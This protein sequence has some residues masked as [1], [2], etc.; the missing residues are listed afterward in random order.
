MGVKSGFLQFFAFFC[1]FAYFFGKTSMFFI[2][3]CMFFEGFWQVAGTGQ[4][5]DPGIRGAET[6]YLKK[7]TR[8]CFFLTNLAK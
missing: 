1:T 3:T 5:F 2:K 8:L 6:E 7:V 4:F